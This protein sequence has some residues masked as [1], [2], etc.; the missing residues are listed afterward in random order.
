MKKKTNK[1]KRSLKI[2]FGFLLASLLLLLGLT[3][4]VHAATVGKASI[5]KVVTKTADIQRVHW[6]R[7]PNASGYIVACSTNGSRY[8]R[9]ATITKGTTTYLNVRKRLPHCN[10]T[11]K[12]KAFRMIKGKRTSGAWSNGYQ[13]QL[14][15]NH[16]IFGKNVPYSTYGRFYTNQKAAERNMK[17][18]TVK[19]WDFKNGKSGAKYTRYWTLTVHKNLATTVKRVFQEIYNGSE[20]FPIHSLGGWRW[21]GGSRTEHQ[22]GTAID[23]NPDENYMI[24][25]GHILCGTHWKPGKDPYSIPTDGE[26]AKIFNKYGFSQGIWNSSQDY[27]HF[28]YF[29]T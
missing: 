17:T 1:K 26:V 22:D 20:K 12:V 15:K 5:T 13:C 19:T 11:Y 27:M 9:V 6:K 7:V 8:V 3:T 25:R 23:I 28:S 24:S 18:I 4:T 21:D 10:Y 29:G 14:N 16:A 2:R